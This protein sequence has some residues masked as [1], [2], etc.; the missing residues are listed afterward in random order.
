MGQ[1]KILIMLFLVIIICRGT[2]NCA[3]TILLP[4]FS[5]GH[6][7]SCPFFVYFL[8]YN[9]FY[10]IFLNLFFLLIVLLL[11][12]FVLKYCA[13]FSRLS[14]HFPIRYT[15]IL[16][17]NTLHFILPQSLLIFL[18]FISESIK[19]IVSSIELRKRKEDTKKVIFFFLSINF[20]KVYNNSIRN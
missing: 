10:M 15:C 13:N 18:L 1:F 4:D 3:L 7:A 17:L 8:G 20:T 14:M 19:Y 2:M 6:D 9:H 16:Q 12:T 5:C 11:P